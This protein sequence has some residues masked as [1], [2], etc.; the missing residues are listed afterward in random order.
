[1]ILLDH[2]VDEQLSTRRLRVVKYR[3]SRHV[4]DET[5][6]M[7][8]EHGKY[9]SGVYL[10][11][12]PQMLELK[13][14]VAAGRILG[15]HVYTVGPYINEPFVTLEKTEQYDVVARLH[16]GGIS[17]QAGAIRHGV[18]RALTEIDSELRGDLKRRGFRFVGPTICYAFM[19]AVGMVDDHLVTCFC[20]GAA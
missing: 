3:G 7:I 5:P 18:A 20:Q 2:R 17:G 6:F 10:R 12:T 11:G 14:N 19:Q 8:D 4:S 15:P 1:M 13:A 9:N 16:G